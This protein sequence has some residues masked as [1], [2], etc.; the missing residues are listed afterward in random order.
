MEEIRRAHGEPNIQV[1]SDGAAD[2]GVANGGAGAVIAWHDDR[3]KSILALPAGR[4]CSSTAAEAMALAAGLRE[5]RN[6]IGGTPGPLNIWAAF[7]SRALLNRLQSRDRH[8]ADHQTAEAAG[9]LLHLG[10]SH[11]VHVL[12]IPGHAGITLNEEA[13]EA[14]GR[15]CHQPQEDIP[16]TAAAAR[17]ALKRRLPLVCRAEYEEA[18]PANHIH[19]RASGGQQLPEYGGRTRH[20]DV[21][22]HQLRLN[23]P[24]YLYA[25]KFKWGKVDSPTCPHCNDGEEDV[26]H[27]LLRCPRWAALRARVFGPSPDITIL[28]QHASRV[29][30][31]LRGA[32]VVGQ[33]PP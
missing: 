27:F 29:L 10:R 4:C 6:N 7:D 28:Q 8:R 17:A 20:S 9:H 11:R 14:A 2:D 33:G 21:L 19:R 24:P 18:T 25:T 23:R 30:E 31:F 3:P 5:V 26:E 12:W 32:G 16:P 1:W 13:D 22:L 15:G